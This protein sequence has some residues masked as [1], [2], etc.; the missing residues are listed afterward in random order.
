MRF[1]PFSRNLISHLDPEILQRC[2][3]IGS[4]NDISIDVLIPEF[5]LK[6]SLFATNTAFNLLS[7]GSE[8]LLIL[9]AENKKLPQLSH[10]YGNKIVRLMRGGHNSVC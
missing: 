3:V 1:L 2:H 6:I 4:T 10:L 8:Y 5:C 7:L 9:L